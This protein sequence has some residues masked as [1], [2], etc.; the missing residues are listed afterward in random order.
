MKHPAIRIILG[1]AV[2]LVIFLGMYYVRNNSN[3]IITATARRGTIDWRIAANG[4]T[5]GASEEVRLSSKI[6]G[7]IKT[8]TVEEGDRVT[9]GQVLV[10]LEND[11]YRA[12]VEIERA[13][14]ERVEAHL[15]L[16]LEGARLEEKEQARAAVD[17]AK[18]VTENAL[19]V[20]QRMKGLHERGIISRD[21]LD[22]AEREYKTAQARLE[23]ATQRHKQILALSRPEEISAAQADVKLARARLEEAEANYANTI[24]RSPIDGLVLKR[25]MR[26][27]ESIRFETVGMPT[28]SVT[29]DSKVF[30]RAEID[31]S[32]VAKVKVGQSATA[33]ADGYRGESFTGTVV[34][35]GRAIGRKNVF[36]DRPT[37][38]KDT[39]V[40]E[41]LIELDTSAAHR[42]KFG[43]RVD[44]MIRIDRKENALIV[45]LKAV[46]K[47]GSDYFVKLKTSNGWSERRVR[48]GS[49]DELNIEITEGLT[50]GDVVVR[51][52]QL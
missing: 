37:E 31:E 22:R 44:V 43:L 8:L 15:R 14:L 18:A 19:A 23:S 25:Y 50:E 10:V 46:S 16:L 4:R 13:A 48:I 45:P 49:Q 12:R 17:E 32:D 39:E 42:L 24:L 27:G 9:K 28:I 35:V 52:P 36:S 20:S 47:R 5:E 3:S 6:P 33:T 21:E 51:N 41:A 26:T 7:R 30:V 2:I 29:D 34:R 11:E 38:R 40:L 1:I